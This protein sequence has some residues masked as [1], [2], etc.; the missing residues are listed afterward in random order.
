MRSTRLYFIRTAMLMAC[1]LAFC[2]QTRAQLKEE[3]PILQAF[4][5]FQ[6]RSV[7]E[8]IYVQTD[9]NTYLQGEVIWMR[10]DDVVGS[11]QKASEWSRIGYVE[12][13]NEKHVALLQA[14]IALNRGR[15]EGSF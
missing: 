5:S 4:A 9:K 8:K 15:G 11:D 12:L 13:L 3:D 14:K 6:S 1:I 2:F 10:L 7:R